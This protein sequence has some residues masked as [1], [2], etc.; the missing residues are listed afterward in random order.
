MR[1]QMGWHLALS[2]IIPSMA[3]VVLVAVLPREMKAIWPYRFGLLAFGGFC[4]FTSI[5]VGALLSRSLLTEFFAGLFTKD[6]LLRA[7][8]RRA[9]EFDEA[10][11]GEV[12]AQAPD[13]R[14]D[15]EGK[16]ERSMRRRLRERK[17][18]V[19]K[20]RLSFWGPRDF[21]ALV[22]YDLPKKY[23]DFLHHAR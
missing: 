19:R 18:E 13:F 2:V 14:Y 8:G 17:R 21:F 7:L 22:G 11:N 1:K 9:K 12:A 16:A 4:S 10:C 23:R 6:E 20:A 3:I 15:D 5:A